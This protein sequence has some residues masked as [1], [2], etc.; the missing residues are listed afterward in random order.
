[1]LYSQAD[2]YASSFKFKVLIPYHYLHMKL[3]IR[4]ENL[5]QILGY[6]GPESMEK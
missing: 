1:M 6:L 3:R 4:K 2:V 5:W